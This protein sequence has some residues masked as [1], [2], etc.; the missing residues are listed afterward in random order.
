M[1]SSKYSKCTTCCGDIIWCRTDT[2]KRMPVDAKPSLDGNLRL[3]SGELLPTARS[4]VRGHTPGE[5]LYKSHFATCKQAMKHRVKTPK[6]RL[7]P[8][9][10]VLFEG[11]DGFT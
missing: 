4:V 10:P 6:R 1:S 3:I 2:G 8:P 9:G 7:P 5:P 11:G